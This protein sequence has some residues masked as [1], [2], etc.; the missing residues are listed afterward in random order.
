MASL[1]STEKLETI[2]IQSLC[3]FMDFLLLLIK[4]RNLM[5]ALA[6]HFHVVAPDFPGFGNSEFPTPDKFDYTFDRISEIM[7]N[8]LKTIGYTQFGLYMQDYGGPVGFRII[9]KHPEWLEWLIVQNTNAYE[10]GFTSAWD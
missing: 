10:I 8:F 5:P 6:S 7:E 4:Y 3:Y 2:V 9:T 1:C